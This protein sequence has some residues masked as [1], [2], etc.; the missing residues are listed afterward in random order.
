[1]SF[2]LSP[3]FF[4]APLIAG[5]GPVSEQSRC[6]LMLIYVPDLSTF[7]QQVNNVTAVSSHKSFYLDSTLLNQVTTK[8]QKN[9]TEGNSCFC[10]QTIDDGLTWKVPPWTA[11]GVLT[12][13]GVLHGSLWSFLGPIS[14]Q[15]AKQTWVLS[16]DTN[17]MHSWHRSDMPTLRIF[18][19]IW[20]TEKK[21]QRPLHT[22]L[23][24][25]EAARP[26][27]K[28]VCS[29]ETFTT[30]TVGGEFNKTHTPLK[31]CTSTH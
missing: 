10:H 22:G 25:E 1:M 23:A 20:A 2:R 4:S 13:K 18:R 16:W 27:G 9:G 7:T 3:A 29:T 14:Y 30:P 31:N 8:K 17:R 12:A 21:Q 26:Q 15:K 11:L 24:G 6:H 5:T 19:P 28:G